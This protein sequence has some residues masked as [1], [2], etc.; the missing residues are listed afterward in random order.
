[1]FT[2]LIWET[3]GCR[4]LM[5]TVTSYRS[6][7]RRGP[8]M[9]RCITRVASASIWPN[10]Y[11]ADTLNSRMEKFTPL[12]VFYETWGSLGGQPGQFHDPFGAAVDTLGNVFVMDT[13]SGRIQKFSQGAPVA[14]AG[15]NQLFN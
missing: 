14:N 12:G 15:P 7:A 1:M 13:D 2:S 3:I 4:F 11:L 9:D 10:I 6:L 5:R 8:V